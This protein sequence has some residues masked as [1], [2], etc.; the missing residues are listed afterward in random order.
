[1]LLNIT[2]SW[3]QLV[4]PTDSDNN[5]NTAGGTEAL[6]K[7]VEGPAGG[8]NNTGFGEN[9]SVSPPPAATTQPAVSSR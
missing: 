4:N 2:P 5:G 3:G 7:V 9:A 1:M 8:F 6:I